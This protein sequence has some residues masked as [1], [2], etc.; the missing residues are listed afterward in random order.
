MRRK[1]VVTAVLVAAAATML[2]A[3]AA[4]AWGPGAGAHDHAMM[5]KFITWRVN[6]VLDTI[7]A[8][9]AQRTVVL[10]A[11]DR[12]FAEVTKAHEQGKGTHDALQAQWLSDKPDRDRLHALVD[13]K[14]AEM[15]RL[16]H[17][18]VDEALAV[19]AA[20]TP[21]QRAKLVEEIERAHG[22]PHGPHGPHPPVD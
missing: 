20:L 17:L 2:L 8:T 21:E 3:G 15:A 16:G 6:E 18:A 14:A 7:A 12:L 4:W 11:K 19:H 10:G 13:A 22:G 9:E 5:G 1:T